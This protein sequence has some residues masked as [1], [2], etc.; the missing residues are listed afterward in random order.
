MTL[1]RE[2]V[3]ELL[4]ILSL[5]GV[6]E[7]KGGLDMTDIKKLDQYCHKIFA[8]ELRPPGPARMWVFYITF[9][10]DRLAGSCNLQREQYKAVL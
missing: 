4:C 9:A 7:T 2:E 5:F 1:E 10:L 8:I 3:E 6:L